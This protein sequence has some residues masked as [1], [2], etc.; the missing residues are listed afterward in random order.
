MNY[1]LH[2]LR[3]AYIKRQGGSCIFLKIIEKPL[4]SW[5]YYPVIIQK[6]GP[7][8]PWTT[9]PKHMI[10]SPTN[11]TQEKI[12]KD[13]ALYPIYNQ[14][15]KWAPRNSSITILLWTNITMNICFWYYYEPRSRWP[16]NV[17]TL[18]VLEKIVSV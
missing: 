8:E 4:R 7:W 9:I 12:S 17:P 5:I 3:R 14:I 2:L 6:P 13:W 1:I 11:T 15:P 18:L 16:D 10:K